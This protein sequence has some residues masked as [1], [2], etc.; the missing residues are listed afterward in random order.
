M[1]API[2]LAC[3]CRQVQM[4]VTGQPIL[5]VACL[6]SDCQE[7]SEVLGALPS[8]HPL[9]DDLGSTRFVMYR[10][11]RVRCMTGQDQ[12]REHR[13]T[14]ASTSRRVV[15]SCCNAP[16]FLELSGG[17]WLSL[18]GERWP[19]GTLPALQMRTMTRDAPDGVVLPDDVPNPKTHTLGFFARLFGAWVAMRFRAPRIDYVKGS[20]D[21]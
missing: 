3:R 10:K 16:M 1:T 21:V 13:L 5:S 18:Y 2:I 6:C 11:D 4:E 9:V 17:H 7:A 15:A 8:A 12:L 20:I 14:P 19:D